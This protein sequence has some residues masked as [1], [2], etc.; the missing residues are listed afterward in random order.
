MHILMA[1]NILMRKKEKKLEVLTRS[2]CCCAFIAFF[3]FTL[4]SRNSRAA[5]AILNYGEIAHFLFSLPLQGWAL[6][7][8]FFPFSH[9]TI[10]LGRRGGREKKAQKKLIHNREADARVK[11]T[12]HKRRIFTILFMLSFSIHFFICR[13]FH[14]L[15][16][17][18]PPTARLSPSRSL[19]DEPNFFLYCVAATFKTTT[20]SRSFSQHREKKFILAVSSRPCAGKAWKIFGLNLRKSARLSADDVVAFSRFFLQY[21][22][23]WKLH[24][25]L[26]FRFIMSLSFYN[27]IQLFSIFCSCV[28]TFLP[29]KNRQKGER[30]KKPPTRSRR[31]IISNISYITSRL[32]GCEGSAWILNELWAP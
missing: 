23:L 6:S 25:W 26:K 30:K 28:S 32:W 1:H 31:F 5:A 16:I 3:L 24:M 11:R 19:D 18:V 22:I 27:F 14:S 20:H 17:R 13:S 29:P 4:Q 21:F 10:C 9:A 8:F 12:F 7:F 2:R 15:F